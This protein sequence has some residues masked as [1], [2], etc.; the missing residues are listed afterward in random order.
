MV[1]EFIKNKNLNSIEENNNNNNDKND[2]TLENENLN[3]K[4]LICGELLKNNNLIEKKNNE[5]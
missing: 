2:E 1:E 5:I 4:C 3:D